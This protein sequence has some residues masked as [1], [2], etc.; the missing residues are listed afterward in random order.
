M[1]RQANSADIDDMIAN[2]PRNEQVLVKKLRA[3][4]IECLPQATEKTY[5]EWRIPFYSR[6]RLICFIWPPSVSSEPGVNKEK[7]K[8]KGVTLG[9]NQ[10]KLMSNEDGVLLA[11]GRKQVYVM[12]FKKLDDID[13]ARVRALLFEAAMI[14]EQFVKK[15]KK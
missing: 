6:N 11:E 15:K 10:G 12:Y 4:I 8:A 14:D 7:Q 13:E 2:L 1:P 5:Y 9:F 3:L